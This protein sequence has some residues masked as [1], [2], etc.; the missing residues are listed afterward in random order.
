VVAFSALITGCAT[1]PQ[2]PLSVSKELLSSKA[3]KVGVAM[4]ALPK[5]DTDFPGAGCLLCLA[6]ASM[7]NQ[8][9]TKHVQTLTA[10]DLAGVKVDMVKLLRSK[11]LDAV[12]IDEPLDVRNLPDLSSKEL[13][14]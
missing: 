1:P 10:E 3:A 7:A 4:T 11:G 8:S 2:P 5:V 9:L 14:F 12:A 13:N 6:A